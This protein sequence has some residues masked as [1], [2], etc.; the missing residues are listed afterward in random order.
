MRFTVNYDEVKEGKVMPILQ[1]MRIRLSVTV[2]ILALRCVPAA[3][4][5]VI[6]SS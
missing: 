4:S 5:V 2:C 1:A 3:R 6:E